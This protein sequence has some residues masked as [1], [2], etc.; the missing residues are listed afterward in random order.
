M[1]D[2]IDPVDLAKR[3][4]ACPSVTPATGDVFDVLEAALRQLGFFVHRFAAGGVSPI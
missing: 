1:S 3:L 4:I 2:A